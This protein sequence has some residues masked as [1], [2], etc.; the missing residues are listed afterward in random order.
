MFGLKEITVQFPAIARPW[1]SIIN[2]VPDR[3]VAAC[4]NV[5][6]LTFREFHRQA[7]REQIVCVQSRIPNSRYLSPL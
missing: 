5:V 1:F 6:A 3:A 2:I 7:A 4:A